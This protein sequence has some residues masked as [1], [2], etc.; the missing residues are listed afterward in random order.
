MRRGLWGAATAVLVLL[1]LSL[2]LPAHADDLASARSAAQERANRAAAKYA[3]AQTDMARA[4]AGVVDLQLRQRR[5]MSQLA[6]LQGQVQDLALA[7]YMRGD[8]APWFLSADVNELTRAKAL[9]RYVAIG[10]VA[11]LD[12]YRATRQDLAA[13]GS[14]L[15]TQLKA[16]Q[17]ALAGVQAEQKTAVAELDRL[18]AEQR[19]LDAKRAAATSTTTAHAVSATAAA[20]TAAPPT[21]PP[22]VAVKGSWVCPVQGPHSFSDDYGQPRPGGRSHQGNDILSPRG[23]PVVANVAGD[24]E[25]HDNG[26]GGIAY[27]LNGA[28]GRQYYGA[29]LDSFARSSGQ[30]AI[31]TVIGYVGNTGDAA[32]GPTHLHFEI[33]VGGAPIDPY[34]TLR[35]YC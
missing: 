17:A 35:Q 30:V 24:F 12:R 11:A 14:K 19:A 29:H 33:H 5:D 1:Q 34:P 23:T 6:A 10:D 2:P 13:A 22:A 28:D 8:T 20:G 31:G 16:R 26:L 15:A 25:Q 18:A 32:G 9:F 7:E 4:Q 21:P 3:Q 27:F